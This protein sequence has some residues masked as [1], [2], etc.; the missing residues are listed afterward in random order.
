MGKGG[1]RQNIG[2][3]LG[4]PSPFP[5]LGTLQ[6]Q[7]NTHKSIPGPGEYDVAK[8]YKVGGGR[9]SPAFPKTGLFFVIT[10]RTVF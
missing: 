9:F 10:A 6:F 2:P 4:K 7:V 5:L 3:K 1:V 8:G